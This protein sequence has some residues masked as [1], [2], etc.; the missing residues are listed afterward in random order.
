MAQGRKGDGREQ[1]SSA[2][3]PRVLAPDESGDRLRQT[4]RQQ[5]AAEHH[6]PEFYGDGGVPQ[7]IGGKWQ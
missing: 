2:A 4:P 7:Q 3:I 6:A 1:S 5:R